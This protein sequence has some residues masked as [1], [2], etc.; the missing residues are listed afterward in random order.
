MFVGLL[1][2]VLEENTLINVEPVRARN[3]DEHAW[4]LGRAR[5]VVLSLGMR[6]RTAG[7]GLHPDLEVSAMYDHAHPSPSSP[8]AGRPRHE[9]LINFVESTD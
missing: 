7:V 4:R 9:S 2:D 1:D 5:F 8:S 3:P 6:A